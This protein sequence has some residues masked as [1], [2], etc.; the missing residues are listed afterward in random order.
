MRSR[1]FPHFRRTTTPRSFHIELRHLQSSC[2]T[3]QSGFV[4]IETGY[5]FTCSRLH[6][7][8]GDGI[9]IDAEGSA[10]TVLPHG[11]LF[12]NIFIF[13]EAS[14]THASCYQNTAGRRSSWGGGGTAHFFGIFGLSESRRQSSGWHA[15]DGNLAMSG[16]RA[17]PPAG[18][19]A[20]RGRKL[21]H[22]QWPSGLMFRAP[23]T[24]PSPEKVGKGLSKAFF[25][26]LSCF[27]KK[28]FP[29]P[30]S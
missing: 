29:R 18:Q 15:L 26:H 25:V 16:F 27:R 23:A 21:C 6:L 1:S 22:F 24:E 11:L 7:R 13:N 20:H 4:S 17:S 19:M 14:V 3:W 5:T 9:L 28:V 2:C 12:R 10:Q 8:C 30:I